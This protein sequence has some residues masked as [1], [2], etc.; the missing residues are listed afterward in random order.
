MADPTPTR[1]SGRKRVP[2]RRY[3]VDPLEGLEAHNLDQE[4]GVEPSQLIENDSDDADFS[5]EQAAAAAEVEVDDEDELV[6]DDAVEG[7][8]VGASSEERQDAAW[9]ASPSGSE[10]EREAPRRRVSGV[11]SYI[12]SE[13]KKKHPNSSLRSRGM[14]EVKS[15]EAKEMYLKTLYGTGV[16]DLV[17][18][19]RSR[20]QWVGDVSLPRRASDDGM[21]GMRRFFSHTEDKRE[22]EATVGWDWYYEKGRDM[23]AKKQKMR[24]ISDSEGR[25]YI[26]KPT[27]SSHSVLLGPY[28]KQKLFSLSQLECLE[29]G[30]AWKAAT[31]D[32]SES[33]KDERQSR[34]GGRAGWMLN[35]GTGVRCLDWAPNHDGDTQYLAIVTSESRSAAKKELHTV[36]PAFTPSPP[37]SSCIQIWALSS[38]VEPGQK[39]LINSRTEPQ[40]RLVICTEWGPVKHLKWCPMPRKS[41]EELEGKISTGLLASVWG[42]GCVRVLDVQMD[43]DRIADTSYGTQIIDQLDIQSH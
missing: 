38:S 31:A 19:T 21:K 8:A 35:V 28:G 9:N 6:A 23:F 27:K 32:N 2:N 42:D 34:N 33:A 36:S 14:A 12:Q 30:E 29:L 10:N 3:S 17:N 22:M 7:S 16:E 15:S 1:K 11:A 39:G 5:A 41:R 25:N 26:H 20:D 40:L 4:K 24:S 18:I 37:S 13:W 43:K